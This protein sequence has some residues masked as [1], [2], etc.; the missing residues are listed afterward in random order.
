MERSAEWPGHSVNMKAETACQGSELTSWG[1]FQ[2]GLSN[3][4]PTA[5]YRGGGR[6]QVTHQG[7]VGP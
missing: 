7:S 6:H 2:E 5:G 1:H 3:G 4:K